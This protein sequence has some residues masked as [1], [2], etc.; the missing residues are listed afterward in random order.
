MGG[1]SLQTFKRHPSL[2]PLVVIV[3]SGMVMSAAYLL[4][5]ALKSPDVSWDRKNNPEP[6]Q[7]YEGKQYK[8]YSPLTDYSKKPERPEF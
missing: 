4:R 1:F 5:L 3:G 8:F 2:I 6:W 7:H